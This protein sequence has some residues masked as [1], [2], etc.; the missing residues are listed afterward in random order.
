[1]SGR[2]VKLR[3]TTTVDAPEPSLASLTM[4]KTHKAEPQ[5][6]AAT[7]TLRQDL[8][9]RAAQIAGACWDDRGKDIRKLPL[10]EQIRWAANIPAA[11]TDGDLT[12]DDRTALRALAVAAQEAGL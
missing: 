1:M 11:G 5:A 2:Q 7:L 8:G 9:R 6:K 12:D 4:T 10:A 3:A